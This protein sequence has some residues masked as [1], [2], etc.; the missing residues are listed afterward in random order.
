M[1]LVLGRCRLQ[2]CLRM[3]K[4]TQS[5]LARRLGVTRQTINDWANNRA[6]MSLERAVNIANILDCAVTDLYEFK[7]ERRG[8]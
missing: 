5:E 8:E 1:A 7:L 2:S 4:M 3:R 6:Q